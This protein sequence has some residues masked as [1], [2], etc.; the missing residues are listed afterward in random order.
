[1]K[2][3]LLVVTDYIGVVA[4]RCFL[5]RIT[6]TYTTRTVRPRAPVTTHIA[7]DR[8]SMFSTDSTLPV[9]CQQL[10]RKLLGLLQ[11]VEP[12]AEQAVVRYA[13]ISP[14]HYQTDFLLCKARQGKAAPDHIEETLLNMFCCHAV[15]PEA[16][17]A[18]DRPRSALQRF[19]RGRRCIPSHTG[20]LDRPDR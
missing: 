7:I 18:V 19:V 1:M 20:C 6:D 17:V 16:P 14:D 2:P 13:C 10:G 12:V 15:P 3:R 4:A 11:G 8:A 9:P 5:L